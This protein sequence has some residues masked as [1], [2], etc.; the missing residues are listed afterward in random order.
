[1]AK[2]STGITPAISSDRCSK[3]FFSSVPPLTRTRARARMR[4]KGN[5]PRNSLLALVEANLATMLFYGVVDSSLRTAWKVSRSCT[6]PDRP[7]QPKPAYYRPDG[8]LIPHNRYRDMFVIH[9]T[10]TQGSTI[11]LFQI[12]CTH[13]WSRPRCSRRSSSTNLYAKDPLLHIGGCRCILKNLCLLC[14]A[15]VCAR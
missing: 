1:L 14:Y 15:I 13:A 6:Y 7:S 8:H 12:A 9:L 4:C 5:G 2:G 11:P 3:A 10:D